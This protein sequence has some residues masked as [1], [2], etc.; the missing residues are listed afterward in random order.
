MIPALALNLILGWTSY[1]NSL[2][3]GNFIIQG[4]LIS[5]ASGI[6]V[7]GVTVALYKDGSSLGQTRTDDT[8]RFQFRGLIKGRYEVV[9][10]L[11]RHPPIRELVAMNTQNQIYHV[12]LYV[13]SGADPKDGERAAGSTVDLAYLRLPRKA[14]QEFERALRSSNEGQY[15][16]SVRSLRTVLEL[17]PNFSPAHNQLGINLYLLGRRQEAAQA[18]LKATQLDTCYAH[19]FFNLG[20]LLNES[21]DHLG[22]IEFLRAGLACDFKSA[23]GFFQLGI[24]YYQ[25]NSLQVAESYLKKA[26]ELD[27]DHTHPIRLELANLYLKRG[28]KPSAAAQ[29][30]AF[31]QENPDAPQAAQAR[32]ALESLSRSSA[33]P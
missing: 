33:T 20:K 17:E 22:A 28:E 32:Q 11:E 30:N 6:P 18:F 23:L 9:A 12:S 15:E 31:L 21:G 19:A 27:S 16:R 25:L 26:L 5:D 29:L 7:N 13:R 10:N 3:V 8:G 14:Q 4:N 24:A 2:G 1:Q